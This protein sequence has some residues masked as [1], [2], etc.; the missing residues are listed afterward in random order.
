V[1]N[2]ANKIVIIGDG[3]WG[4]ALAL[5]LCEKDCEMTMWGH[6][7]AYLKQ[8][9]EARENKI[10]LSGFPLPDSLSFEPDLAAAV[11]GVELAI[12]AIPTKFLRLSLSGLRGKFPANLPVASLTKG[13]EQQTL[14]RPSEIL[15]E[16]LGTEKIC[17]VSGPSHAEEV[18][19][20][21]PASVVAAAADAELAQLVQNTL[22][23]PTFR[24][25]TSDDIIGVE[26][27]G[28][29]KNVIAVAA[30]ICT[31][32]G[33]G[34]NAMAALLTRGVAEMTRLGAALGAKPATFAGLSGMGD[35]VTTCVSPFG[36]NR[37]VGLELGQGRKL[38]EILADRQT[39]AEGV[40][41]APG[42]RDL[43][44]KLGVDLPIIE[45]VCA[46]LYENKSPREAV[47][48]LMTREGKAETD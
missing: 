31:G 17:A 16:C 27:G 5:L 21:L 6:D 34:D 36:R 26:L 42:A 8:M 47:R 11:A 28:A 30:G 18:A 4:T 10:F 37:A 38:S 14:E 46:V 12:V 23:S 1:N 7:P 35:L 13:V 19:K 40:T 43:G 22:M 44:R 2:S 20:G 24:V 29:L 45:E 15:R 32:L 25:Y 48:D 33:L 39:V 41:T 9:R 3:G